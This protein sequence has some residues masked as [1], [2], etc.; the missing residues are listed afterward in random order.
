MSSANLAPVLP[1]EPP[2]HM[3]ARVS[4]H[5]VPS[6]PGADMTHSDSLQALSE[7]YRTPSTISL[8][9]AAAVATGASGAAMAKV[10]KAAP[11]AQADS[12]ASQPQAGLGERSG[13]GRRVALSCERLLAP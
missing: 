8:P 5:T 6:A 7:R 13:G 1:R 3:V 9:T 2:E 4:K 12:P 10:G 11:I